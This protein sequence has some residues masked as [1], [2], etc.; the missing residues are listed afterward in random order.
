MGCIALFVLAGA[1]GLLGVRTA[2]AESDGGGYHLALDYATVARAGLDVPWQATVTHP[3]GF[4]DSVTLAVTGD[5]FD[6]YETQGFIPDPASAARNADTLYL[7]FDAPGGDTFVVSYDAYIQPSSQQ[8][9]SG[10]IGV[11]DASG[12]LATSLDFR[13]RL[14]P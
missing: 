7:T 8:G 1:S 6:I 12:A 10:T 3:G 5:Y 4:G 14:L 13:T 2:T 9:R 11:V